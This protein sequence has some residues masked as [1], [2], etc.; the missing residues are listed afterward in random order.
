M[1]STTFSKLGGMWGGE[2]GEA[3]VEHLDKPP[4]KS[5][6]ISSLPNSHPVDHK[7]CV[8]WAPS[9]P[10][11]HKEHNAY[12]FKLLKTEAAVFIYATT[13]TQQY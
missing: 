4:F 1:A 10:N 7:L 5:T 3:F 11:L 6:Y 12:C 2:R 9:L 8:G 13:S